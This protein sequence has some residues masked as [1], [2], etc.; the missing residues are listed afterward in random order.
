MIFRRAMLANEKVDITIVLQTNLLLVN[1]SSI[2]ASALQ[3]GLPTV[4]GYREH[5]VDG[6]LVSY[7]VDLRWCFQRAEYFAAKILQGSK[8][9]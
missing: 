7:G 4:F 5:V 6:G 9:G 2:A 8:T 3:K 1:R